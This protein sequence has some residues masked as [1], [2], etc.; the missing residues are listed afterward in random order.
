MESGT[1]QRLTFLLGDMKAKT[2]ERLVY[3]TCDNL[4]NRDD[5]LLLH[6]PALDEAF[7]GTAKQHE[8]S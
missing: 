1:T 6:R 2:R 5:K 7:T 8:R 4:M 3:H